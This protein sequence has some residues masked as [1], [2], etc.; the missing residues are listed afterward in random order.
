MSNLSELLPAGGAAKEF[1]AVA[2]GTLPN[3]QAVAL[4]AN[5]QVEAVAISP[6][7]AGT[8]V[9]FEAS[10]TGGTA[11]VFDTAANKVVVFYTDSGNSSYG[12]AIVGA[13]SGTTISFGTAVVFN[14]GE[15]TMLS[16]TFDS[17]ANKSIV[18]YRDG[19]A[20]NHGKAIVGTV[21]GTSISFGAEAS[22]NA[23]ST[24]NIGIGFDSTANKAVVAFRDDGNS[25][26]GTAVVGTVSGT[27]ISFGS[28]ATFQ[29]NQTSLHSVVYDSVANKTVILYKHDG[30]SSYGKATVCTVSG[31]SI[32]F[33]T[34]VTFKSANTEGVSA[35]FDS[36]ANKVVIPYTISGAGKAVVGTVSGTSIS[37]GSE[38]T[39]SSTGSSNVSCVF[40]SS[41]NKTV[42]GYTEAVSTFDG[43]TVLGTVS[44]TS[45]SFNTAVNFTGAATYAG[46]STVYDSTANKIVFSYNNNS[47]SS[48]GT[49][50][51]YAVASSSNNA[52]FV[53]FA[54]EAI[55]S[56]ATG[57]IVPKGGVAASVSNV[58][59]SLTTGSKVVFDDAGPTTGIALVYDP[60]TAKVVNVF[61]TTTVQG[62]VGT[63]SGTSISYGS[64]ASANGNS[65]SATQVAYDTVNNKIVAVYKKGFNDARVVIGTVSGTA[66]SWGTPVVFASVNAA[67]PNVAF[68]TN[69]GKVLIVYKDQANSNHGKA[70]V[71]T[72]SGTSISI[73]SPVTFLSANANKI[74]IAYDANAQKSVIVVE[75]Y[76]NSIGVAYVAT[77]SGTSVSF[78]SQATFLSASV[79][80][81]SLA[82]TYNSTDNKVVIGYGKASDNKGYLITGTVS[83]TSI[84][85]AG[86]TAFSSTTTTNY[87]SLAYKASGNVLGMVYNIG[88]STTVKVNAAVISGTSFSLGTEQ[89]L[90]AGATDTT[91]IVVDS[92][93]GNFV[94][95]YGDGSNNN[96]G[97]SNVVSASTSLTIG[98]TY[99]VQSDGSVS[100][101]S[102]SPAVILGKAVSSTSLILKGNS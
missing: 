70:V 53:G 23:G 80:S 66:I 95:S 38:A 99:Y 1:E 12:T 51:V 96:D 29:T 74:Q 97:T 31:T 75:D 87:I 16:A 76:S 94:A 17:S 65:S 21:S 40:D 62:I 58:A 63:V 25:D 42:V 48:Y 67:T 20:S 61:C 59:L 43:F 84:S 32:S 30:G 90:T 18:A 72:V 50:V 82:I 83:G 6:A 36:S 14:S 98:S 101:V 7:G 44:G 33:G 5:G 89:Q 9:V 56:G 34:A 26:Y 102:T 8:P 78:G 92:A 71:G 19:V 91:A 73:G 77:I 81:N 85:F 41:A 22:F 64:A 10:N 35:V 86:E 39:F 57:A 46:T 4:K 13:V 47:N 49:S 28:E 93:S 68:D 52:S 11:S 24:T 2:S 27:S 100:T 55:S 79:L 37:F 69:S 54:S 3:G 15:A 88:G 60:D 45:I